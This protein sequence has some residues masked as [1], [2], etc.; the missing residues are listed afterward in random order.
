MLRVFDQLTT[1][2]QGVLPTSSKDYNELRFPTVQA[3]ELTLA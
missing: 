1:A 2:V 3:C